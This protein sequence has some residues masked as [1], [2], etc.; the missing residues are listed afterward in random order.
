M[1]KYTLTLLLFIFLISCKKYKLSE[2][3]LKLLPYKGRETLYFKSC[4]GDIDSIMIE[5]PDRYFEDSD[6]FLSFD[7]LETIE[8]GASCITGKGSFSTNLFVGLFVES[9]GKTFINITRVPYMEGDGFYAGKIDSFKALKTEVLT[10]SYSNFS[11]VITL[12]PFSNNNL[13]KQ[14]NDYIEKVFWSK[15]KGLVR[16]ETKDCYWELDNITMK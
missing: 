7:K 4:K 9:Y 5:T 14:G 16:Y 11:D 10:T 8:F 6:D 12:L 13:P 3:D 2:E 1:N 15:S